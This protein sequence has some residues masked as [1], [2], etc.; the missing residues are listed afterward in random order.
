MKAKLQVDEITS[1]TECHVVPSTLQT[2][3][4]LIGT[5]VTEMENAFVYKAAT[6]FKLTEKNLFEELPNDV[7]S[8]E[9]SKHLW[10]RKCNG[11][12]VNLVS[13][14]AERNEDVIYSN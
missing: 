4:I 10:Y 8:S 2:T 11:N 13:V 9:K 7:G 5:P 14:K 6:V 12:G 3:D 1:E